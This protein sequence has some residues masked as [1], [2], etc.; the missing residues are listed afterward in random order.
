MSDLGYTFDASQVAP[1]EGFDG[2][3]LP[4][5]KYVLALT[6]ATK[7]PTEKGW[8]MNCEYTVQDGDYKGRKV[9]DFMNLSHQNE[10]TQ[11]IAQGDLSALCHATGVLR[12]TNMQDL[13]NRP[14]LATLK[15]QAGRVVDGKTYQPTNRIT[16][17]EPMGAVAGSV[18]NAPAA[19]KVAP[20]AKQSA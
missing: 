20:W 18:P 3:P 6:L 11:S 16:K 9:W 12:V 1:N 2:E 17:R 8:G 10:Q 15:I 4:V 19:K 13:Y 7:K 14:F 5:G